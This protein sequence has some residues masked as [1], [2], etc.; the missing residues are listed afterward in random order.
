MTADAPKLLDAAQAFQ[1]A[2]ERSCD[3][4]L[5]QQKHRIRDLEAD[6]SAAIQRAEAA[7]LELDQARAEQHEAERQLAQAREALRP[8]AHYASINDLE[9]RPESDAI[10]VPI[11][12]LLNAR[13]ALSAPVSDPQTREEEAGDVG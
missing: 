9:R 3:E 12:D 8:F 11:R 1:T 2:V 5:T 4:T 6:L 13:A 7:E 10:E